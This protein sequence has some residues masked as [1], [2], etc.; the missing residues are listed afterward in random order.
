LRSTGSAP[1]G[2]S[3][4]SFES[5]DRA[6]DLHPLAVLAFRKAAIHLTSIFGPGP[7]TAASL[8]QVD[9][10]AADAQR[11]SGIRMIVLGVVTGVGQHAVEV[12]ARAGAAQHGSQQ[13]RIVGRSV[14]HQ[15]VNQQ[16][17]GVVTGKRQLRPATNPIAFLPCSVGIMRRAVSRLQARGV[18]AGLLFRADHLPLDG[19]GKDRIEQLMEQTF[20]K[21]RCCAL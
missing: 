10:R 6:L 5:R 20:F 7:A 8:V 14:V 3:E 11:F 16:M 18:D 4:P 9:D 1:Q 13:R 21:R 17:G 19:V 15:R 12:H 2:R